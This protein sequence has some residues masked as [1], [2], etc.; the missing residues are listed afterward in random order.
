MYFWWQ[1][2]GDRLVLQRNN[3]K[4]TEKYNYPDLTNVV[5]KHDSQYLN[6]VVKNMLIIMGHTKYNLW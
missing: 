3:K 2:H 1:I 4:I 5:K 6:Y